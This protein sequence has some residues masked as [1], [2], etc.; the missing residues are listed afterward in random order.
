MAI[1]R[2]LCFAAIFLVFVA[3]SAGANDFGARKY[4]FVPELVES[5][6]SPLCNAYLSA[7]REEFFSEK[8]EMAVSKIKEAMWLEWIPVK[9][10]SANEPLDLWRLDLDP[11]GSGTKR[12]VVLLKSVNTFGSGDVQYRDAYLFDSPDAFQKW[13]SKGLHSEESFTGIRQYYPGEGVTSKLPQYEVYFAGEHRWFSFQGKPYFLTSE[14]LNSDFAGVAR[15][16]SRGTPTLVCVVR[17]SPPQ[18]VSRNFESLP[19]LKSYLR[20]LWTIGHASGGPCGSLHSE[21]S[22]DMQAGGA[23][24]RAAIR[25][26]ATS[27]RYVYDAYGGAVYYA[28]DER[29]LKYVETWG[30]LDVW[31]HREY[32]TY[33]NHFQP[34]IN[35]LAAYYR[36]VFN[37]PEKAVKHRAQKV[38]EEI[39][40]AHFMIPHQYEPGSYVYHFGSDQYAELKIRMLDGEPLDSLLSAFEEKS[41]AVG[42]FP[43]DDAVE[44]PQLLKRRVDGDGG[45]DIINSRNG[46]GKTP[47]MVAAHMNRPDSVKILLQ[48]GADPNLQ[49]T[50][51]SECGLTIE[52]GDR[53]ALMYAAENAD[54]DVIRLLV[55]AGAK[56]DAKDS[57]GSGVDYYLSLSPYLTAAQKKM[58][59]PELLASSGQDQFATPSFDCALAKQWVEKMICKDPLSARQDRE[60]AAAFT[61]WKGKQQSLNDAKVDQVAWL[62]KRAEQCRSMQEELRAI[63]CLQLETRARI[64]Y[65]HNRI[66][67]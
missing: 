60:M 49:T 40:G 65:L 47:L 51:M 15:L 12:T 67:E 57:L 9:Q 23:I 41:A 50:T 44:H 2:R 18:E 64:R 33:L 30:Y 42:V 32:Q 53:T 5:Q 24:R 17:T 19:G 25:P 28:Y 14:E 46:W 38:F 13:M 37:V 1:Y 10:D 43:I 48:A 62:G 8:A 36:N 61:V 63:S 34:A 4:P 59:I 31:N 66:A 39:T 7:V 52:R 22:H 27:S 3:S 6:N 58:M 35:A 11:D 26:W 20:V 55:E 54:V 45:R 29:M 56:L 21:Y 16:T